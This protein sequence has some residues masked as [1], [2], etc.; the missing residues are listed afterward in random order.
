MKNKREIVKPLKKKMALARTVREI[1]THQ[2]QDG[3][4]VKS[5]KTERENDPC[6]NQI[7]VPAFN[8]R[9]SAGI[10]GRHRSLGKSCSAGNE[11]QPI[12]LKHM[13]NETKEN[14]H[15]QKQNAIIFTRKATIEQV[16]TEENTQLAL[17]QKYAERKNLNVVKH[18]DGTIYPSQDV[19]HPEI[20][21]ILDYCKQN[22]GEIK[23]LIVLSEDR[24]SRDFL[25]QL[26]III[27]FQELGIEV[28]T[29][30][31]KDKSITPKTY[32]L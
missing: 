24:L 29:V 10:I 18:F 1:L 30:H 9:T 8:R 5:Q 15:S 28:I 6:R 3:N 4:E 21:K 31:P 27:K 20:Q 17:C 12:Y 11:V 13:E 22:L 26:T 32:G 2:F 7:N 19:I 14:F 16:R 25:A 23:Y